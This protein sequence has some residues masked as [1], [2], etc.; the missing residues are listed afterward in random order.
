VPA[1]LRSEFYRHRDNPVVLMLDSSTAR[2]HW[3]ALAQ[4]DAEVP[5]EEIS[6]DPEAPLELFLGTSRGL[7]RQLRTTFAP[8]P[9]PF[10]PPRRVLRVLVVADPAEDNHLP[11]AEQEGLEVAELFESFNQVY[12]HG[13]NRVEVVKLFGPHDATRTNVLR[14]LLMRTEPYDVLHFAGHCIFDEADKA[15]SGWVF[16]RGER[17]TANELRRL[18][19]VPPFVF[20]N[21]CES[22]KTPDRSELRS[23]ELAP[24]FAESFFERGVANFVCTAWPVD[25]FAARQ[26]ALKLYS[27]LLGLQRGREG[28]YEQGPM[29]PMYRAMQ[30]ARREIATTSSGTRTWAAYQHYGSPF[31]RLFEPWA[32][33]EQQQPEKPARAPKPRTQRTRKPKR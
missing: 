13:P 6:S 22:G 1:E 21:A 9:E 19:R 29:L 32:F 16:S 25:D 15:A 8:P 3:E 4:S 7:T 2:I 10:P 23:V 31:L 5:S 26:F 30:A 20:S 17:L 27:G 11:G 18:D 28:H 12:T 24:T 33:R 14:H